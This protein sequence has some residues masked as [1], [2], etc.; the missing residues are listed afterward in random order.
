MDDK[1]LR[2][3][4]SWL[5]TTDLVEASYRGSGVGAGFR[6]E[7]TGPSVDAFP[8]CSLLP[9]VS[10][11]VG[12]FRANELG[13]APMAALG[14]AVKEGQ[15]LGFVEIGTRKEQVRAPVSGKIAAAPAE[16]GQ[17]V[18]YGQALFFIEP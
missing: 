8:A 7:G 1:T 10:P 12:I 13:A 9:V 3:I 16:D 15:A 14:A 6:M 5:R 18:Q 4:T 2:E 17:A 11:E